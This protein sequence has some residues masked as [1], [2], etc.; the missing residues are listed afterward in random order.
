MTFDIFEQQHRETGNISLGD[1]T[2]YMKHQLITYIGNKRKLLMFIGESVKFTQTRLGKKKLDILDGFAGSGVVSRFFKRSANALY[3]NDLELYSE[4]IAKCYLSNISDININE[5]E[6]TV[7]YLNSNKLRDDLGVGIIEEL[8]A[9]NDDKNIQSSERAFY[10]NKNSK[11]IDNIRR[12]IAELHIANQYLYIAPLL[13]EASVHT[14]TSGVF[15]GFYK[16]STTK[17]GQFGGNNKNCLQRIKKDI[18]ISIPI[19]SQHECDVKVFKQDI[20]ELIKQIPEVDLAYYDPPYNQHPYSSNYFMLNVIAEYN[21]PQNISDVS[22]IPFDWQKSSYNKLETAK[23]SFADL[24]CNTKSK[25][26]AISYNNEGIIPA[27][28]MFDILS[29]FGKTIVLE[30]N[31]DTF[32]ASRNLRNRSSKVKEILYILE[33]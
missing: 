9:P 27:T 22:G 21:K 5:L 20:N 24:I 6:Q 28:D 26:I 10:T 16:N 4:I 1:N 14:N 13:Y 17:I 15:K 18:S 2:E 31:Y 12:T 8:Y 30:C 7:K 32:K 33:K 19:F 25:V 23:K 29:S 3:S 11:I